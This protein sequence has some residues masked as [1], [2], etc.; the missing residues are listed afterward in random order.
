ML[1][2]I[3]LFACAIA[4]IWYAIQYRKRR[5]TR[6]SEFIDAYEFPETIA[7]KV[8][9][10]Y[11]H[12]SNSQIGVVMSGL[13]QYFQ[14]CNRAPRGEFLSMPSQ[15]VDVAWHEFILFTRTYDLFCRNALGRFLHHTPA[16]AMRSPT[17]AQHGIR[18]TWRY[19]CERESINAK[20]PGRLPLLFAIDGLLAIPDGFSFSLDCSKAGSYPYCASDIGCGSGCGGSSGS[21]YG[22]HSGHSC[23]DSSNSSDTGSCSGGSC[24]GGGCG[25][26]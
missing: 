9:D 26:D 12:L 11:P 21:D 13:K 10:K 18:R 5:I 15:A 20:K 1:N 4:I 19:A 8:R 6:R 2:F 25:G 3:I 23:S 22:T 24:G 16:E 17:V 14:L 7:S